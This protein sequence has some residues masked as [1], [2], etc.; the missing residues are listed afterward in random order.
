MTLFIDYTYW[1]PGSSIIVIQNRIKLWIENTF[2]VRRRPIISIKCINV[3]I[4]CI[5]RI[6]LWLMALNWLC[7]VFGILMP[8]F[9]G[10]WMMQWWI[11]F[12]YLA[13]LFRKHFPI[14]WLLQY[15]SNHFGHFEPFEKVKFWNLLN[16]TW[17]MHMTFHNRWLNW[18][19]KQSKIVQMGIG[20]FALKIFSIQQHLLQTWGPCRIVENCRWTHFLIVMRTKRSKAIRSI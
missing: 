2:E 14:L 18:T 1:V 3:F 15:I 20:H 4:I 8:S 9:W 19:W 13:L 10:L 5:F 12:F 6:E 7:D 11:Q 16:V 17:H